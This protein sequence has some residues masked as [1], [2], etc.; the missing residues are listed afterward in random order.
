MPGR[1]GLDKSH[2]QADFKLLGNHASSVTHRSGQI[3]DSY[4]MPI[5]A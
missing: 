4:S 2:M 5:R 3:H 1:T